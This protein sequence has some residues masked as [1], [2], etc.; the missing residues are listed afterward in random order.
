MID[1]QKKKRLM[2]YPDETTDIA[3]SNRE[4]GRNKTT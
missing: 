1:N 4:T 2:G 3:K